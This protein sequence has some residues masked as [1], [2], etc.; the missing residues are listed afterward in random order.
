[1]NLIKKTIF[2]INAMALTFLSLMISL[3]SFSDED[4]G[5]YYKFSLIISYLLIWIS[6]VFINKLFI[7]NSIGIDVYNYFLILNLL[8]LIIIG[9]GILISFLSIEINFRILKICLLMYFIIYSAIYAI[10]HKK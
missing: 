6:Y 3:Y 4:G 8:F 2:F 1:M 9:L 5:V 7:K 10:Y